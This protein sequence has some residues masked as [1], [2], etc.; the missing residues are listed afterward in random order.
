MMMKGLSQKMLKHQKPQ[1]KPKQLNDFSLRL[2]IVVKLH[3]FPKLIMLHIL[4]PILM[5]T[6]QKKSMLVRLK[7]PKEYFLMNV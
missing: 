6:F 3:I 1:K 7:K 5:K 2:H 4:S